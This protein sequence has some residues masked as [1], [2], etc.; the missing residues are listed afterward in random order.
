M[1]RL[2]AIGDIHGCNKSLS[3]LI[4][5]MDPSADDIVVT[6]GDYVDRGP[7]T[8]GVIDQ[9][10]ELGQSTQLI[11]LIGNHEEMMLEV[12]NGRAPHHSWLRYGGVDTL[13]SYGFDGDLS[14]LPEEHETFFNHL[15]DFFETEEFFFAHANY[16][17]DV[18]LLEQTH[19]A[20]RWRSLHDSLPSPHRN[21]KVA[22]VGHT[23][24]SSGEILN[25]GHI[26][27]VD[28]C[29]YGGG[30]LSGLEMNSGT[31]YQVDREGNRRDA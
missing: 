10:I 12:I 21:G 20:L 29:C 1:S 9:L 25:A 24:Q 17:A 27:C 7:D 14:F 15:G 22:V 16:D 6:L 30:Y 19:E 31:L 28:T 4:R 11:S 26:I 5:W 8:R 3:E 18:P 2:F 13:E 23:A